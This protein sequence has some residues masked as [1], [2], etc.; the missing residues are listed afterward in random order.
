MKWGCETIS[1]HKCCDLAFK[2]IFRNTHSLKMIRTD[3]S[4]S[5]FQGYNVNI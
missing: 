4:L 3:I 2:K 5:S 1:I